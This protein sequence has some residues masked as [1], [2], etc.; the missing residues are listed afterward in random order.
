MTSATLPHSSL[1]YRVTAE[2]GRTKLWVMN[3]TGDQLPTAFALMATT[4]AHKVCLRVTGGCANMSDSDKAGLVDY[5]RQACSGFA[6]LFFTGAT[7]QVKDGKIDTMI[8][9]IPAY[10]VPENPGSKALGTVPRTGQ[11]SL[12]ED[13]RFEVAEGLSINPGQAGVVIVQENPEANAGWNGDLAVYF[14]L[15][16]NLRENAGFSAVGTVAYNGGGVTAE[17]IMESA[18]RGWPTILIQ[19]SGRKTDEIAAKLLAA[20]PDLMGKLP[21]NHKMVVVSSTDPQS[22][23]AALIQAGFLQSE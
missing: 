3:R 20:D 17:E 8:T 14:G 5:F 22:L 12:V 10:L 19:G 18:R 11:M 7:R 23:H 16:A 6:G 2:G 1:P 15:M 13:S 9:D 21:T 4:V